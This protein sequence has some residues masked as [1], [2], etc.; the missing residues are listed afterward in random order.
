LQ[1]STVYQNEV[2][3][4]DVPYQQSTR[5]K[6]GNRQQATRLEKEKPL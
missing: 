2:V 6:Q 3:E 5:Q 1:P 4:I